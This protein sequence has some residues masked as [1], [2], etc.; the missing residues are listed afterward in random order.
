MCCPANV[1]PC[2]RV[3]PPTCC[4]AENRCVAPAALHPL[5]C[6]RCDA[7]AALQ[8]LRCSRCVAPA[9]M[10][11]DFSCPHQAFFTPASYPCDLKRAGGNRPRLMF[12]SANS[13]FVQHTQTLFVHRLT[14]ELLRHSTT[15]TA[16]RQRRRVSTP[17]CPPFTPRSRWRRCTAPS[18]GRPWLSPSPPRIACPRPPR[19]H[20]RPVPDRHPIHPAQTSAPPRCT[21]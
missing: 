3:A 4:P 16:V 6:T 15:F 5:R 8:P 20:T 17:A 11:P 12:C 18:A 21:P 13:A 1:L 19:W 7:P 9:A 14:V 2:Q 10:H